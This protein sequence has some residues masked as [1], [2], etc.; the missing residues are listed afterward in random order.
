[1]LVAES[2]HLDLCQL[3]AVVRRQTVVADLDLCLVAEA[4]FLARWVA[5]VALGLLMGA[6]AGLDLLEAAADHSAAVD[7]SAVVGHLVVARLEVDRSEAV[8]HLAVD[9]REVA[10]AVSV[11]AV[12]AVFACSADASTAY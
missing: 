2:F 3:E 9:Q 12:V 4:A 8:D 6:V 5:A 1:M 7:R 10:V 11:V